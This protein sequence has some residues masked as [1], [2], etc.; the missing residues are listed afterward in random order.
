MYDDAVR[1]AFV[2]LWEASDRV[3]GKRLKP[4]LPL[5]ISTLERHGHLELDKVVRSKLLQISSSTIDRLLIPATST[6]K[7]KHARRPPAVRA[8]I[9]VRTFADWN[10]P[11]PGQ[12]EIDLVA[13]C[14]C[15][16]NGAFVY[17]LVLT[18]IASGWIECLPMVARGS[19]LVVSGLEAVCSSMPFPLFAID[20]DNGSELINDCVLGFC[21]TNGIEFTRAR[22]RRKNDQAW[23]EQK[24]GA[25]V[26][27]LTGFGRLSGL[28]AA[29][30]LAG[31]YAS[32][33]LFVNFFQP[34]SKLLSKERVGA[35]VRKRYEK[36]A[37]PCERLL[38]SSAMDEDTKARLR[39]VQ[40]ALDPL[41]LLDEIRGMQRTCSP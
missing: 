13:H 23:V 38:A 8:S 19:A 30:A 1:E 21:Q 11:P 4:L 29:N 25:V 41:R 35:R 2:V 39:A 18:D 34:S 27:R 22:P 37:T 28:A 24:N 31:L 9:R 7:R 36:P 16:A 14:G 20:S 40:V 10:D 15:D 26:R 33:R 3:Y 5:L 6:A 32:S 12:M 17:T